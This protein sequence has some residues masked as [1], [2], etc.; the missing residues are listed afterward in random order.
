MPKSAVRILV[1]IEDPAAEDSL[2]RLAASLANEPWG[3]LHLTHVVTPDEPDRPD[4]QA[5]L[6]RAAQIAVD[7]GV[8]AIPH[9]VHGPSVTQVIGEALQRWNCDILL[10]GWYGAVDR[11]TILSANNRALTKALDVDT[12]IFKDKGLDRVD[13][14]LVPTGGGAHSL[15]GI[16]VAHGISQAWDVDMQVTRVARDHEC[17]KGDPLLERYRKQVSD[18][19]RLQLRLLDL[20]P[21]FHEHNCIGIG[22]SKGNKG[23]DQ[24]AG[25]EFNPHWADKD[26]IKETAGCQAKE[27]LEGERISSWPLFTVHRYQSPSMSG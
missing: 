5:Q 6:A 8:G 13:R 4:A 25:I 27:N 19:L 12:L 18:D 14:V 9:V 10:M 21:P 24:Y 2:V 23:G 26:N 1:A 16:E 22:A 15:M 11:D 3:E 7:L 17:R 20:D